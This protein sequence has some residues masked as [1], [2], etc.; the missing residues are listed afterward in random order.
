MIRELEIP[1][2]NVLDTLDNP[3]RVSGFISP[4]EDY[5]QK[6]LHI[7]QRIVSD[8]TNTFYFEADDD[9]MRYFGIMKGSIIIVDKSIK[10]TS[11]MLIVCCIEDEWLTRKLLISGDN[12]YLCINDGMDACMNITGK[13]I[14]VFG[15]VTWTCLPHSKQ[16][17]VR[18]G[19]L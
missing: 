10:V 7:A 18:T 17:N 5:K 3:S 14:N 15:A 12:T 4:A 8:P 6:R 2:N 16:K 13:N 1:K 11:G 19:R 9:H